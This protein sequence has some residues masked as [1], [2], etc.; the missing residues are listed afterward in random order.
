M[1]GI[2]NG[3]LFNDKVYDERR[4]ITKGLVN[5]DLFNGEIGK[6]KFIE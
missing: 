3:H 2:G 5:V 1:M 6:C 4:S